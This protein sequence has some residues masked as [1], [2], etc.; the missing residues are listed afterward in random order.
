MRILA[1]ADFATPA[2]AAGVDLILSCGDLPPEHLSHL[3][4]TLNAP[5][6]YVCGNHDR[7]LLSGEPEGCINLHGRL[8]AYRGL[9][10]AGF[11]GSRWYNGGPFQ[12]TEAQ[13]RGLARR[14]GRFLRGG[15]DIVVT[16]APPRRIHDREDP[17]HQGFEAFRRLIGR[18][19]PGYFLHGHV[20][21]SFEH[22][23][24]RVTAVGGTRVVNCSGCFLFELGHEGKE[25]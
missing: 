14:M 17:C 20:H 21:A 10:L 2:P 23:G 5:V 15:L 18:Y 22:P 16:H 8:V 4:R 13:M 19:A 3:A 24:E 25:G 11:E 7:R 9:R 1:V 12:Y 6:Y